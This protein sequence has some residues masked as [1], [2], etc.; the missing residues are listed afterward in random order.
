MPI[1]IR[2]D[3]GLV[4][5]NLTIHEKME[6]AVAYLRAILS[7]ECTAHYLSTELENVLCGFDPKR[8]KII[9]YMTNS[10][11]DEYTKEK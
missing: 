5:Y 6:Y 2:Y 1:E 7:G 8:H 9:S 10:Q 3:V 4:E 11:I